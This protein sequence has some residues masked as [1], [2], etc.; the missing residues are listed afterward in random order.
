MSGFKRRAQQVFIVKDHRRRQVAGSR[1][2]QKVINRGSNKATVQAGKSLVTSSG[3][4]GN[5]LITEAEN[6]QKEAKGV[7]SD[8]GKN[9]H[10]REDSIAGKT[11]L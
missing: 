5:R 10:T 7:V 8:A 4:S 6:R 9:Y 11:E 1:G 2:R 3:R